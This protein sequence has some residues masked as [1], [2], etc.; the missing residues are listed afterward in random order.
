MR[1]FSRLPPRKRAPQMREEKDL[2]VLSL[3]GLGQLDHGHPSFPGSPSLGIRVVWLRGKDSTAHLPHQSSQIE[4]RRLTQLRQNFNLESAK[5]NLM[6]EKLAG[7]LDRAWSMLEH[8]V[9][10]RKSPMHLGML[11]TWSDSGPQARIVVLREANRETGSLRFHT[12]I[13][14]PKFAE[15]QHD[16]RVAWVFYDAS[17]KIQVRMLGK[18][19]IHTR[20]PVAEAA[21]INTIPFSRRCY[22][23]A[24][25]PGSASEEETSGLPL[26]LE[27]REPTME[28]SEVGRVNFCA[29]LTQ[30]EEIDVYTLAVTGHRRA[31]F[32]LE[33]GKVSRS[34]WRAP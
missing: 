20:G 28:E 30:I 14:S 29:V 19:E 15:L 25:A 16:P 33:D 2:P 21:W 6:D 1:A 34:E 10:H 8:A 18:A 9:S 27:D 23:A 4:Y 26:E 32:W 3:I 22:M 31:H 7:I 24:I 13:R 17:E 5:L 11:A 12:D